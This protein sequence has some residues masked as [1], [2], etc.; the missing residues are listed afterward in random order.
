MTTSLPYGT[1]DVP[2]PIAFALLTG[3]AGTVFNKAGLAIESHEIEV[4]IHMQVVRVGGPTTPGLT[5][6]A[7]ALEPYHVDAS[8]VRSSAMSAFPSTSV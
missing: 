4:I 1:D 7:R 2:T 8:I 6:P 3:T 5:D